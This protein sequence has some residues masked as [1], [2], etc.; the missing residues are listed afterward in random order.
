M[1][2]VATGDKVK[3][4]AGETREVV[5][6]TFTRDFKRYGFVTDTR[7]DKTHYVLCG[8]TAAHWARKLGRGYCFSTN[9]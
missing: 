5:L 2:Y 3:L 9:E 6:R 8:A 7:Y 1:K 4:D